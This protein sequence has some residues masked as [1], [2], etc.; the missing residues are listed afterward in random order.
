MMQIQTLIDE[1]RKRYDAQ[2]VIYS[3]PGRVNLIG[4][5]TDYNEGFVL[6]FAIDNRTYAAC[7]KRNDGRVK[8]FSI[9]LNAG[10]EFDVKDTLP[11][12][13]KDWTLYIRGMVE[14]LRRRNIDI[15]GANLL[16]DSDIP[17]GGGLSSSAALEIAVGMALASVAGR[18]IGNVELAFAGQ[19]VE[20]EFAGVM[21]GIMDQ[22]ASAMS[23]RDHL[24]M[25]DCRSLETTQIPIDLG[26]LVFA[27]C[28][29]K[30]KHELADS[31]YNQRRAECEQG[32]ELLQNH[33]V[34]IKALRDVTLADFDRHKDILPEAV[35]KRCLHVITENS[36]TLKAAD[37]IR[38]TDFTQLGRLMHDSH[39]SLK[40][41]Y[42]VSC[43]ELDLLV[44][45]AAACGGVF[46]SRM[47]G[48]GFGG[49]T[50]TLLET[51]SVEAFRTQITQAY[52]STFG[53]EPDIFLVRPSD[54]AGRVVVN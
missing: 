28:D 48:G 39:K 9:T 5:H 13:E 31:A 26:D 37:A 35:R 3:A 12:P 8:A 7:S 33:I 11:P 32:V 4:E 27:V 53:S 54:G 44:A 2:P 45:T 24:L 17:F 10:V 46:G 52:A 19:E 41:N 23:R 42:E 43:P 6:P 21:S 29:T 40:T 51:R 25:I 1:F 30:V 15:S 34:G 47:T 38:R 18:E 49:C 50:I 14:T 16:I 36:R 20:H 22:F